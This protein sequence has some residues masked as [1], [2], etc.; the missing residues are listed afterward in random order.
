MTDRPS[1]GGTTLGA[2]APGEAGRP[3]YY[4]DPSVPGFV[5][6]W[7]GHAWVPGTSRAAP[8]PGELLE[9]P[10][11]VARHLSPP[12]YLTPPGVAAPAP[13]LTETGPVYLD[14][15]GAGAAFTMA[16]S[17]SAPGTPP[18]DPLQPPRDLEL[19]P[20]TGSE[21]LRPV[22]PAPWAVAGNGLQPVTTPESWATAAALR[23]AREVEA[24]ARPLELAPS[25]PRSDTGLH[26]SGLRDS[27]LHD[28][29]LHDGAQP[30]PGGGLLGSP[31]PYADAGLL[32]GD[33]MPPADAGPYGDMQPHA[34]AAPATGPASPAVFAFTLGEE[35]APF[36]S[37][38]E[39]PF[40]KPSGSRAESPVEELAPRP[41]QPLGGTPWHGAAGPDPARPDSVGLAAGPA[42]LHEPLPDRLPVSLPEPQP[43]ADSGWRADPRAQ[44]GLMET[45][46]A[47]RWVSWGVESPTAADEPSAEPSQQPSAAAPRAAHVTSE[48]VRPPRCPEPETAPAAA[49]APAPAPAPAASSAASSA[50]ERPRRT[51][52]KPSTGSATRPTPGSTSGA[53]R[54]SAAPVP[55][56]LGARA[57]A[58][59]LD[60]AVT[61]VVAAAVAVP[62]AGPAIEHLQRKVERAE[63]AA[64]M[65]GHQSQ[66]LLLDQVVLGRLGALLGVL[67]LFGLLYQVL[68]TA[69]TGQ[70]FGKRLARVRVVA[71]GG[72]RPPGVGRSLLRWLVRCLGTVVLIGLLAPLL[73]RSA[74]RGWHDRAARTRVV[75]AG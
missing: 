29:G 74:R 53:R 7:G 38:F 63:L 58:W 47:P 16:A 33:A 69:R 10:R 64:R 50:A 32:G 66:V 44:R 2:S 62:V 39:S 60:G 75:R 37:P 27:G 21:Q 26:D 55:A 46:D 40:A 42:P 61:T 20:R 19:R 72:T 41:A 57:L 8:A 17:A 23:S 67:L 12:P 51:P 43:S 11:F 59:L 71:A 52:S 25:A 9:P 18:V 70:T 22:E 30:Y 5:R 48:R 28:S 68:P 1:P 4:P 65:T 49:P 36:E 24:A 31:A 14:E 3:G 15:T 34:E 13:A 6:Y 54:G 35:L 73:D 45:G 56:A